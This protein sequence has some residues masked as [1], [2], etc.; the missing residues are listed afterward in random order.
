MESSTK[1]NGKE[2]FV[3]GMEC[4]YGLMVRSIKETGSTAK[5][6]ARVS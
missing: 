5:P 4:R 2:M 1:G 3:G 6:M